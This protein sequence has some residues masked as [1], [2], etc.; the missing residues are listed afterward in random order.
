MYVLHA[1]TTVG[2]LSAV[3]RSLT[4]ASGCVLILLLYKNHNLVPRGEHRIKKLY[5]QRYIN[6][7]ITWSVVFQCRF[8]P[9]ARF[10]CT[11]MTER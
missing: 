11:L 6:N 1:R 5:V 4:M 2:L 10:N 3:H 9:Y 8:S 7:Y